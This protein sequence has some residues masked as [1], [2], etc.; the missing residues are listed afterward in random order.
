MKLVYLNGRLIRKTQ[1]HWSGNRVKFHFELREESD[2]VSIVM[3]LQGAQNDFGAKCE[4]KITEI[5]DPNQKWCDGCGGW[6]IFRED[7]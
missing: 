7:R 3:P 5:V 4:R 6:D 2:V 1:Y